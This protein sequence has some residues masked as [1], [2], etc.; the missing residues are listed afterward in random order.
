MIGQIF[1]GRYRVLQV[2]GAGGFGETYITADLHMPG[3]PQCVLKHLKP[4]T[5]D[6]EVLELARKLFKKEAETLQQLGSHPQ[7][8]RLLAF[9]EEKQEFYLVQE[10]I[11]GHTLSFEIISDQKWTEQ[12][13]R[14]MLQEVLTILE[15]VH[16][17]GVI[18]RDIKP[19]NIMRRDSNRKLVLIDFG[20]I[21][22]V[23]NQQFTAIGTAPQTI[24]IGTPGYMSPEQ[25]RGNPRPSSDL[26]ALGVIAIQA[27][28]GKH[29]TE[30]R[31][32]DATGE[33]LWQHFV[34]AHPELVAFLSKM[35]RYHFRDR[36]PTATQAIQAL[37]QL[38][39]GDLTAPLPISPMP[40]PVTPVPQTA[41]T[42]VVSPAQPQA[43][44]PAP[45][46]KHTPGQDPRLNLPSKAGGNKLLMAVVGAGMLLGVSG[47]GGYLG[48][49]YFKNSQFDSR[50]ST[51]QCRLAAPQGNGGTT[52]KVRHLPD[53]N[54]GIKA[55]LPPGEKFLYLSNQEPFVEIQQRDGS[56]GWVFNDQ[57]DGCN[58]VSIKP[59]PT[60]QASSP[61][62]R[63][64]RSPSSAGLTPVKKSPAVTY[65][66][67]PTTL[68]STFSPS[69]STV[70]PTG[71]SS[72]NSS[73]TSSPS[74][75]S[76]PAVSPSVEIYTIPPSSS[77][78]PSPTN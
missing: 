57:I 15:F 19:D 59:T 46:P 22:Q 23:R 2:L 55:T 39:S 52:T 13:V 64:S 6:P 41:A 75:S 14:R 74:V 36:Y 24:A 29:P 12:G 60:P 5:K 31:E 4:D 34:Q 65:S 8:P 58:G 30:I 72:P 68:P 17:Q 50:L 10:F 54:S 51:I 32:D 70:T 16:S 69:T 76:S 71:T 11:E 26:Y 35:T 37:T 40:V 63:S 77:A 66:T 67:A 53:R 28:S 44:V 48:W 21:K 61:N 45:Q 7:I 27:I 73:S 18:H 47:V 20:A 78:S 1:A 3:E 9:F 25:A 38:E 33:L 49:S 56:R 62:L 42:W 43:V